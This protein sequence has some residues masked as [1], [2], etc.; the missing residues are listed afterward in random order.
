VASTSTWPAAIRFHSSSGLTVHSR[1]ARSRWAGLARSTRSV[2]SATVANAA[3]LTSLS[4]NT[5]QAIEAPP[6]LAATNCSIVANG[7]YTLTERDH[8]PG[9][10]RENAVCGWRRCSGVTTYGLCPRASSRPYVA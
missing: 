5:I 6:S 2:T 10:E 9:T 3:A 7:P 8:S 1:W 4:Q